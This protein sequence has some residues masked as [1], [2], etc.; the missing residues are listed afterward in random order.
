M[1]S[2]AD[3]QTVSYRNRGRHE[4][5]TEAIR[6]RDRESRIPILHTD[7]GR[8][9]RPTEGQGDGHVDRD[10]GGNAGKQPNRH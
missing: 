10:M 1:E 9:W 7:K 8:A 3:E 5:K 4:I 2:E 6:H